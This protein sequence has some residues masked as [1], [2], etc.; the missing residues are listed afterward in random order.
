VRP[1]A[2]PGERLIRIASWVLLVGLGACGEDPPANSAP[3]A[4]AADVTQ[5]TAQQPDSDSL[6]LDVDAAEPD[7]DDIHVDLGPQVTGACET[8]N[9]CDDGLACNGSEVCADGHCGPGAAIECS[10]LNSP[11]AEGK[12][13]ETQGGCVSTPRPEQTPCEDGDVCTEQDVCVAGVCQGAPR[14]CSDDLECSVDSCDPISGGCVYDMTQCPCVSDGD[15]D[16]GNACNG[17]ESCTTASSTCAPGASVDCSGLD[18]V[19]LSGTCDPTNGTCGTTPV[20]AGSECDD[21]S[22]CTTS[23][24]CQEGTCVGVLI[25]CDDE[26]PCSIDV[27]DAELGG[28]AHDMSPCGCQSDAECDDDNLCNGEETCDLDSQKCATGAPLGCDDGLY[29][30]G[31]ES[32]TPDIGCGAG[33]PPDMNDDEPCTIDLCDEETDEVLH[34]ADPACAGAVACPDGPGLYCGAEFGL[35]A[36]ALYLC[37]QGSLSL[38]GHCAGDCAPLPLG[39]DDFCEAALCPNGSGSYCGGPVDLDEETLYHCEAGFFS[40]IHICGAGCAIAAD[41]SP[42]ACAP[43]ACPYGMG[44]YCGSTIDLDENTLYGCTDG[45][46]AATEVCASGCQVEAPGKWDV[47]VEPICPYGDGLYCGA[48]PGQESGSLYACAS[49][50]FELGAHCIN[51]CQV[52]A[53]GAPDLCAPAACPNGPGTYCGAGVGL[54]PD[55]LYHCDDGGYTPIEAC[56]SGCTVTADGAP[57]ICVEPTCP[58]GQGL[59]CGEPADL[60]PAGLYMCKDGAFDLAAWCPEGCQDKGP[61]VPDACVPSPCPYG[62]G[63]YCGQSVSLW[64][65]VLFTCEQS[66]YTVKEVCALGC[67]QAAPGY[68]DYC[69]NP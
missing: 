32:C 27:C 62:P 65:N 2:Y 4:P 19:C 45:T 59:Y 1:G 53:D 18:G 47:C 33:T 7:V 5:E 58:F 40:A 17:L 66:T 55:S 22:I 46:Y 39:V 31:V 35:D 41:G 68:P 3:P 10:A 24:A 42:D 63:D 61:G 8:H 12:C 20:I 9:D 44:N 38:F 25:D 64:P 56:E 67:E 30:N 69:K 50:V 36:N 49:G 43:A 11:C 60:D 13:V 16:D 14:E 23:D 37:A 21:D 57:D 26:L 48:G 29:C 54:D 34:L 52:E 51:G 28:C 6:T 15:C